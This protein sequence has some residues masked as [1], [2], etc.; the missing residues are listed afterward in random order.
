MCRIY[1]VAEELL[2]FQENPRPTESVI[3]VN[4]LCTGYRI[5]PVNAILSQ[6][7]VLF[8]YINGSQIVLCESQGI[9]E[10]FPEDPWIH[11]C[12]GYSEIYLFLKL[13]I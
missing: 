1:S 10:P 6:F 7:S 4:I 3:Y 12:D 5:L 13:N 8:L 9:R 2:A 11:I